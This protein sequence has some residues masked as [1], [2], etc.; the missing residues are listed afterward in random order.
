M[1]S[2]AGGLSLIATGTGNERKALDQ[3]FPLRSS[4]EFLISGSKRLTGAREVEDVG[5]QTRSDPM[6][7][8][9]PGKSR[10]DAPEVSWREIE[11]VPLSYEFK[12]ARYA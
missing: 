6:E 1:S 11:K 5:K 8:I 10:S 12:Q 2:P 9:R 3:W 4:P 7:T